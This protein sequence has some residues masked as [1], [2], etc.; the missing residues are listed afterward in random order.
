[1]D[2]G[3]LSGKKNKPTLTVGSRKK[4]GLVPLK[5]LPTKL[6][7][8]SKLLVNVPSAQEQPE[9]HES[10]LGEAG[11]IWESL[12]EA[13]RKEITAAAID[14]AGAIA[15]LVPF[16]SIPGAI[17]GLGSTALFLSAAKDRKGHIDASDIGQAA[18]ATG[19]DVVSLI[20]YMGEIGKGAKV[21]KAIS[22]VAVP[23]GK[24]FSALGLA[25]ASSVLLTKDPSD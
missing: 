5:P 18:L 25:E 12:T 1:M 11:N 7:M 4:G 13:D 16:G 20:P 10:P 19:L 17:S 23:L 2:T 9:L 22:K 24:A 3:M 6:Q 15:G 14:V 21:A 8:G